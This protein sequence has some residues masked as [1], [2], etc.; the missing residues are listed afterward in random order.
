[1]TRVRKTVKGKREGERRKGVIVR[2][3]E[4]GKESGLCELDIYIYGC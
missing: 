2:L 3:K 1:V 4:G